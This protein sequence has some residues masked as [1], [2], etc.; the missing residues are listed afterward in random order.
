MNLSDLNFPKPCADQNTVSLLGI[1]QARSPVMYCVQN[2]IYWLEVCIKMSILLETRYKDVGEIALQEY[3]YQAKLHSK[4][5]ILGIICIK[6]LLNFQEDL[7]IN[8]SQTNVE[9]GGMRN[10]N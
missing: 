9:R 6:R 7:K 5:F 3:V 8:K 2:S 4:L 10:K 1:L